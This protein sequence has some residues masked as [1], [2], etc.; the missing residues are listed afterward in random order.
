VSKRNVVEELRRRPVAVCIFIFLVVGISA[1]GSDSPA[2]TFVAG[3][4]TALIVGLLWRLGEPPALLFAVGLQ[5]SQVVM[6]LLY[7]NLLGLPIQGGLRGVGV[8]SAIWFGLF[9][10]LV[11]AVGMWCG[12]LGAR[13]SSSALLQHEAKVWSPQNAFLFCIG[14]MLLGAMFNVLGELFDSLKQPFLAASRIQWIGIFV[15]TCVCTAQRRGYKYLLLIVGAEVVSGFTG[16]FG[17]FK[18]VFIVVLLGLFSTRVKIDARAMVTGFLVSAA[19]LFLGIFWSAVK[20]DYRA[21]INLGSKEQVVLV[22]LEDR[23]TY[24]MNKGLSVDSD[25]IGRGLQ[26]LVMRWAYVDFLAA[27]MRN[28]PSRVPFQDGA[29]IGGTV[30]HVVQPRFL[31]PDKPPLPSDTEVTQKYTGIF[32]GRSTSASTS[33]SLGYLA[34]LYVD[35]GIAGA[36]GA[37]LVFGLVVGRLFKVVS[38]SGPLPVTVQFGLGVMLLMP[39]MQFEHALVKMVGAFLTTLIVILVLRRFVLPLLLNFI[40]YKDVFERSPRSHL[41]ENAELLSNAST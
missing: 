40:G 14:T 36:L 13:V 25:A 20:E 7:A 39:L 4:V 8:N 28:V 19:V 15:L 1:L 35:F 3:L 32:F 31:F 11:L 27:T 33:I 9:A 16:Y 17:D 5:L 6:P 24:L 37:M 29:Q 22:P 2:L 38:S 26:T 21:F 23:L 30:L 10:M 12:Q 18:E 34:E 41:I